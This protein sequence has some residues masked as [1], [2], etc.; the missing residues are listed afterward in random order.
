MTPHRVIEKYLPMFRS[1]RLFPFL[2]MI[3]KLNLTACYTMLV[4][5]SKQQDLTA[6]MTVILF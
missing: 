6:K 5:T 1:N 2:R 3:I 4:V